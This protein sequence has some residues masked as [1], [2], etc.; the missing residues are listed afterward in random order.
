MYKEPYV[1]TWTIIT[2][3]IQTLL[4]RRRTSVCNKCKRETIN[5]YIYML[6][7]SLDL[8]VKVTQSESYHVTPPFIVRAPCLYAQLKT[9][10]TFHYC[11]VDRTPSST[12]RG[13]GSSYRMS[14]ID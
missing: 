12:S 11:K 10:I 3:H 1:Q 5:V 9:V 4:P 13:G 8:S 2:H 6:H 14:Y 7:I